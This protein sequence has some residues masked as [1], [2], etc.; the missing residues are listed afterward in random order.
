MPEGFLSGQNK[1]YV[2]IQE[3]DLRQSRE[4][5]RFPPVAPHVMLPKHMFSYLSGGMN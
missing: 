3:K 5:L 1:G 2:L 4:M